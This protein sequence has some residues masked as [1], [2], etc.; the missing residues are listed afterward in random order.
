MKYQVIPASNDGVDRL[1]GHRVEN[2]QFEEPWVA[3]PSAIHDSASILYDYDRLDISPMPVWKRTLDVVGAAMALVF[4]SPIMLPAA[5]AI[6]L[7]SK[8]PVIFRQ[9]RAG[10]RGQPFTFYKFRSMVVDAESQKADL[11][12]LNERSAVA[13][14]IKND[15]RVTL[16]GKFMRKTSLDELPQLINVLKGNMSLVG[17][18]PLPVEESMQQNSWHSIRL[19]VTPGIT[20]LWQIYARDDECF[21]RWARLDIEYIQKRSLLFDLKLLLLTIPA[22]LLMKGAH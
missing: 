8:G 17:P 1:K 5:I 19:E 14:K 18:R 4:F 3:L 22:V 12:Q 13:F 6:K 11:M 9:E 21:D 2:L 10:L 15:P 7:T 20:C 16:L